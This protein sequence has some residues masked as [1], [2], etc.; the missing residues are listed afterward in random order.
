MRF[1]IQTMTCGGCA[2]GVTRAVQ[3]VD[4]DAGLEIDLSTRTA[5]VA[6]GQPRAAFEAALTRA[7]FAPAAEAQA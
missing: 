5:Q 6:S 1:H 3:S 4:P 2:R 7:G